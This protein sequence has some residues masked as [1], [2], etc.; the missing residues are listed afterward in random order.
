MHACDVIDLELAK[1]RRIEA[2]QFA[3]AHAIG[4]SRAATVSDLAAD[5]ELYAPGP[6]R[7]R[8][9]M[10]YLAKGWATDADMQL[11]LEALG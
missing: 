11:A 8:A 4:M 10:Y 5:L 6:E 2:D 3:E 9:V 1:A 7:A